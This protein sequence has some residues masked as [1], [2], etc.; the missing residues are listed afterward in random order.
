MFASIGP[1]SKNGVGLV[2]AQK[3]ERKVLEVTGLTEF[4][5]PLEGWKG[6]EAFFKWQWQWAEF[7]EALR[8]CGTAPPA[9]DDKA[10]LRLY[11]DGWRLEKFEP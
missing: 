4:D 7:P 6:Q 5:P 8:N 1:E 3:Y 2:L 10:V 11:D 9:V